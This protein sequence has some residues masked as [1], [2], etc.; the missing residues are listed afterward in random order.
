MSADITE[1]AL[2]ARFEGDVAEKLRDLDSTRASSEWLTRFFAEATSSELRPWQ[3]GEAI[4]EAVLENTHGVVLPW[5]PRR[6]QRNPRASLPG[7]D[8]VGISD[9]PHGCRLVFGEVKSSS[10]TRSPPRVLAGSSG[11]VQQLER[12]IG[13]ETLHF[14]LIKWLNARVVEESAKAMFD[15]ALALF[16]STCGSAVRFVGMLV[17]DTRADERDVSGRGRAL[18]ERVSEPGSVELHALYM[19]RPMDRWTDWVAA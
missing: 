17:R 3:V 4:A 9:E 7:P 5:N 11:M 8:L 14:A 19:P 2:D 13:D 16:V 10:D 12:L 1:R 6:D 18:G 15:E